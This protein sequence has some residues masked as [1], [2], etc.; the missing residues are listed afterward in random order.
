MRGHDLIFPPSG[1]DPPLSRA[2]ESHILCLKRPINALIGGLQ[3][4]ELSYAT[5]GVSAC[6]Q[7]DDATLTHRGH[8]L[9]AIWLANTT[10]M[11]E[12]VWAL[13]YWIEAIARLATKRNS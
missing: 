5:V 9:C 8:C 12:E 11:K 6:M 4:E 10:I 2:L 3:L 13:Q 1:S 7:D